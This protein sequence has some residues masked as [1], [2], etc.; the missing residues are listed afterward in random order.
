MIPL[1]PSPLSLPH[2]FLPLLSSPSP[3]LSI[4]FA[5]CNKHRVF[6]HGVRLCSKWTLTMTLQLSKYTG[7]RPEPY[8]HSSSF[9]YPS[10]TDILFE[11]RQRTA[12]SWSVYPLTGLSQTGGR[13]LARST[14][15]FATDARKQGSLHH[16][17]NVNIF[18][19]SYILTL[20]YFHTKGDKPTTLSLRLPLPHVPFAAI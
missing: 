1:F 3:L 19:F 6:L 13:E 8:H 14:I 17:G 11:W 2:V 12:H 9:S 20:F 5:K 7:P 4:F 16:F 15:T 10:E 18:T